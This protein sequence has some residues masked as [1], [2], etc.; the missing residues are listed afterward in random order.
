VA[1]NAGLHLERCLQSVVGQSFRDYE[2]IVVDGGS[3]DGTLDVI[4]RN[5][6]RITRWVS[7][8]DEGVYDG[9][10]KAIDLA[11]GKWLYFLG[12]DDV[13]RDCLATVAQH[14]E[15]DR[16]VYYGDVFRVGEGKIYGG[17]FSLSRM[18]RTN[19]CQ[20]AIFYPR[21]VFSKRRF[22]TRYAIQADWEF[23]MWCF[24]RPEIRF[25]H[26]PVLVCDFDDEGGLSSTMTDEQF[27]RDYPK[28]LKAYFP[29]SISMA[30]RL[31]YGASK[32]YRRFFPL[33]GRIPA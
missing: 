5:E 4:M 16:T 32:V 27:Q 3:E 18:A 1:L 17:E 19:I 25:R 28:M 20:Q 23:N 12:S 8:K 6:S 26:V 2:Y 13:M 22:D 33:P 14:L 15:D 30:M 29:G 7:E 9:M 21:S 31:I 11:R 24:S 10:N